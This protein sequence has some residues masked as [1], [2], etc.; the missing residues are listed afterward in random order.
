MISEAES[1]L[2]HDNYVK[3][4]A[5][6]T[7]P[8]INPAISVSLL[9]YAPVW[10]SHAAPASALYQKF[11][12]IQTTMG[13]AVQIV[14]AWIDGSNNLYRSTLG[15]ED[16]GT[17]AWSSGYIFA[18]GSSR[19]VSV[20]SGGYFFSVPTDG[21]NVRHGGAGW[22]G[23]FSSSSLSKHMF[24]AGLTS[25]ACHFVGLTAK[26]NWRLCYWNGTT[27][28]E[29]DVYWP[30]Q[31]RSFD[32]IR[33][34][35]YDIVAFITDL[36]PIAASET[37]GTTLVTTQ[38]R[39]QGIVMFKY[40]HARDRWSDHITVDLVDNTVDVTLA[41][42]KLTTSGG[43]AYLTYSRIEGD[44]CGVCISRSLDGWKWEDPLLTTVVGSQYYD[45]SGAIGTN[46]QRLSTTPAACFLRNGNYM[47]LVGSN[48]VERSEATEYTPPAAFPVDITRWVTGV[49]LKGSAQRSATI[50]VSLADD[51]PAILSDVDRLLRCKVSYGYD[52]VTVPVLIGDVLDNS[53]ARELASKERTITVQDSSYLPQAVG[54]PT[55]AEWEQ[56]KFHGDNFVPTVANDELGS[57]GLEHITI[58]QGTWTGGNSTTLN[59]GLALECDREEGVALVT[60][61][62]R[63]MCGQF[64][65]EISFY[66][67]IDAINMATGA[68]VEELY[69]TFAEYAGLCIHATSEHEFFWLKYIPKTQ[70]FKLMKRTKA[71]GYVVGG[72]STEHTDTEL[73]TATI[74]P[75]GSYPTYYSGR[76]TLVWRY[77]LI[78]A[79]RNYPGAA[80]TALFAAY[81]M[82]GL[83]DTEFGTWTSDGTRRSKQANLLMGGTCGYVAFSPKDDV[84]NLVANS[85]GMEL[86]SGNYHPL[87]ASESDGY[88]HGSRNGAAYN[89]LVQ[90]IACSDPPENGV[91]RSIFSFGQND[92]DWRRMEGIFIEK[93]ITLAAGDT[94][95]VS[96]SLRLVEGDTGLE[97]DLDNINVQVRV[98]LTYADGKIDTVGRIQY[99]DLRV[100]KAFSFE[101]TVPEDNTIIYVQVQFQ[102][103]REDP[104][105]QVVFEI[106]NL[107][108]GKVVARSKVY[109]GNADYSDARP[110]RSAQDAL[111]TLLAYAGHHKT[112]RKYLVN[113]DMIDNAVDGLYLPYIADVDVAGT[114]GTIG[115]CATSY[116][117][118]PIALSWTAASTSISIGAW[119]RKTVRPIVPG[120][121][122]VMVTTQRSEFEMFKNDQ[123][124][125]A[126]WLTVAVY[127]NDRLI[128]SATGPVF[129]AST[130]GT[131]LAVSGQ[132]TV[133]VP[134]FCRPSPFFSVDPGENVSSGMERVVGQTRAEMIYRFNDAILIARPVIDHSGYTSGMKWSLPTAMSTQIDDQYT[135]NNPVHVRL[136]GAYDMLDVID[137]ANADEVWRHFFTKKDDPNLMTAAEMSLEK[138]YILYDLNAS[139]RKRSVQTPWN[140]LMERNDFLAFEDENWTLDSFNLSVTVDERGAPVVQGNLILTGADL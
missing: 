118:Y 107:R 105:S 126:D 133:Q 127:Q 58:R 122:R 4:L 52:G 51:A 5:A 31:I 94:L 93:A 43:W 85:D 45:V 113:T 78:Y 60:G 67:E 14:T 1:G 100:W 130:L 63:M 74:T 76:L 47:Y 36:P 69:N 33:V 70:T 17:Q 99:Q 75:N 20:A 132:C 16:A 8:S 101:R 22:S 53:N 62:S 79:Y 35:N 3:L 24:C 81:E 112:E 108:V 115:L 6:V 48:R 125:V 56:L 86:V 44:K 46:A 109:F 19:D 80:P 96:G 92:G 90:N 88:W 110:I 97:S 120:T 139:R 11:D 9:R 21:S 65:A 124:G 10:A 66:K 34:G 68:Q 117:A 40:D 38:D 111:E 29:S 32:A 128:L 25:T 98:R 119:V 104:Q 116:V 27:V 15:V 59:R 7:S 28:K 83:G 55:A 50:N 23:S 87:T 114:S 137:S 77:G 57:S 102:D 89:A 131:K 136:Q 123:T 12:A 121:I 95:R 37:V 129:D 18:A 61:A 135:V 42:L 72:A 30:Y 64:S 49:A 2:S 73:A 82:D 26:N 84:I 134:E 138:A 103:Q 54:S 13:E 41:N 39:V 91:E 71:I 106:N 140:P